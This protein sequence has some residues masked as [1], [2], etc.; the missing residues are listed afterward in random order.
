MQESR[1]E[2][3]KLKNFT[4]HTRALCNTKFSLN[5]VLLSL[6]R[7]QIKCERKSVNVKTMTIFGLQ[8][9]YLCTNL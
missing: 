1:V 6:E 4:Y 5:A 3:S 9:L 2:F 7:G 8:Q